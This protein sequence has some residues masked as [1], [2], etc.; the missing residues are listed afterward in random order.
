MAELDN[1][2]ERTLEGLEAYR[3]GLEELN[4]AFSEPPEG[5]D[6]MVFQVMALDKFKTEADQAAKWLPKVYEEIR[7]SDTW[8]DLFDK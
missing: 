6:L 4:E 8:K 7:S 2:F 3:T 5:R 1:I